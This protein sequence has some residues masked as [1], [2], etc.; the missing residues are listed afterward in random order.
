MNI[1]VQISASKHLHMFCVLTALSTPSFARTVGIDSVFR[2]QNVKMA[3]CWHATLLYGTLN[4][5]ARSKKKIR[6]NREVEISRTGWICCSSKILF[7]SPLFFSISA[8]CRVSGCRCTPLA[9]V[10][11]WQPQSPRKA[12]WRNMKHMQTIFCRGLDL[13]ASHIIHLFKAIE[14][15]TL[16]FD[17]LGQFKGLLELIKITDWC[18]PE[19]C[20]V[21]Y[22]S[23]N[24]AKL[25]NYGCFDTVPFFFFLHTMAKNALRTLIYFTLYFMYHGTEMALLW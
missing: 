5:N 11:P 9:A 17:F 15:V 25:Q 14:Q 21:Q 8:C 4:R 3:G 7:F 12:V 1:Y 22:L 23:G 19:F 16:T 6:E 20:Y 2:I 18:K 24:G 10:L 13:Y